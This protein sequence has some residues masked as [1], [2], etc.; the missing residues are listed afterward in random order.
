MRHLK[1]NRKLNRN[2]SHR[3]ALFKNMATSF[4]KYKKIETTTHKAKE[5]R[6]VIE[7]L[8][9]HAKKGGL[10]KIRLVNKIIQDKKVLKELFENIAPK[11][12]NRN[13]GYTS[14]IKSKIRK[15]DNASLSIIKLV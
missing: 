11:Y 8:L 6:R 14:V 3:K 4:F 13:G 7:K 9:T 15:G 5:V 1:N 10:H 12:I 2:S